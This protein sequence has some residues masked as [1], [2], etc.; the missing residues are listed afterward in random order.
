MFDAL[1]KF[2]FMLATFLNAGTRVANAVDKGAAILEDFADAEREERKLNYE[3]RIADI[4]A[5]NKQPK[6]EAKES[7]LEI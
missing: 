7:T 4:R 1:G 2:W 5:R 6:P 3:Q